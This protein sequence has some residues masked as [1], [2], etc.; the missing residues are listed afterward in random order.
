[1]S[2]D[3]SRFGGGRV[4]VKNGP[5]GSISVKLGVEY[6]TRDIGAVEAL[7]GLKGFEKILE[8]ANTWTRT[9]PG[10]QITYAGTL[11]E[12]VDIVQFYWFELIQTKKGQKSNFVI[13]NNLEKVK[14]ME[15][16]I[17]SRTVHGYLPMSPGKNA[18]VWGVDAFKNLSKTASIV[19]SSPGNGYWTKD[20]LVLFDPPEL[21]LSVNNFMAL[22]RVVEGGKDLLKDLTQVV[23]IAHFDTYLVFDKQPIY[24]IQWTTSSTWAPGKEAKSIEYHI[25]GGGPVSALEPAQYMALKKKFP[26][27][28]TVSVP[29]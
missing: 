12:K 7:K 14:K 3:K 5:Q 6:E 19:R 16:A 10:I 26:E 15:Q 9:K 20:S 21:T 24:R 11:S 22:L 29:K 23:M 18:P 4:A 28:T 27:Q 13:P 8:K 1:M 25:V 17:F 2:V